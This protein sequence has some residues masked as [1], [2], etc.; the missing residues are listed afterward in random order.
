MI[1]I[2]VPQFLLSGAPALYC[3]GLVVG[4][5]ALMQRRSSDAARTEGTRNAA[6]SGG[7]PVHRSSQG[8]RLRVSVAESPEAIR[9]AL[10]LVRRRYEWRGYETDHGALE[11]RSGLRPNAHEITLLA[12]RGDQALGTVT[13]RLDGPSGLR[14]DHVYGEELAA[15]RAD[16]RHVCELTRLAMAETADWKTVLAS[17]LSLGYA[18]GRTIHAVTDVFI[19]V[20]PRH[21]S[22]YQRTIGFSIAAGERFCERVAAPAVLLQLELA[23][24]EERLRLT[25]PAAASAGTVHWPFKQAAA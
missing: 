6:L 18:I 15:V 10:E 14:A 17:L 20:N 19:E 8:E 4:F 1:P 22:F 24:L 11:H 5:D 13:L 2:D 16:G 12:Q 3:A 9:E 23:A 7:K 21:V 25:P